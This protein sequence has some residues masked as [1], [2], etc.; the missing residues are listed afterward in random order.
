MFEFLI[1]NIFVH[2]RER[3][4]HQVLGIPMGTNCAPLL[5]DLFLYTYEKEILDNMIRSGHRRLARSFNLCYRYI[6]NLI[7]TWYCLLWR[8]SQSCLFFPTVGMIPCLVLY[9]DG[10]TNLQSGENPCVGAVAGSIAD[11][12][13][14]HGSFLHLPYFFPLWTN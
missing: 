14:C 3:L 8:V 1:D 4:F 13:L 6:D 7:L 5:A 11:V 10:V 12:S 9:E 2:F